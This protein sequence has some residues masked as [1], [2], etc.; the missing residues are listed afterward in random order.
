MVG[1]WIARAA[2]GARTPPSD[3]TAP[4]TPP[5]ARAPESPPARPRPPT[6][7]DWAAF[8]CALGDV[9]SRFGDEE[10]WLAGAL[11]FWEERPAAV[12]FIAPEAGG[13]R[14]VLVR[15]TPS[16]EIVWLDPVP[17]SDLTVGAEP[18]TALEVQG[19]RYERTRRLPW[20]VTRAGAGAPDVGET[21]VFAEYTGGGADRLVV[22]V[23]GGTARAFRGSALDEGMYDVMPSGTST[24]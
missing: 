1:R 19:M 18:P 23:G 13:D 15:P 4:P 14:A 9:V 12:L 10:R 6:D 8:P 20:R 11:V 22:I 5:E 7:P 17:P 21:A 2:R 16:T 24:L 3:E